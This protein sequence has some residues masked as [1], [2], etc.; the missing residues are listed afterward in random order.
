MQIKE[1]KIY[2]RNFSKQVEFYAKIIGLTLIDIS[3]NQAVFQIGKSKL[4]IVGSDKFKPYHFAINIPC[5]QEIRALKWLKERVEILKNGIHEIQDFDFWNAK[6]IYFYDR[7]HNIVEF[8]ARKNLQ[9]GTEEE[10]DVNSL[11][12]ISEIGIPVSDIETIFN[13]LNAM[14]NLQKYDGGFERFCAIGDE[15]GLFICINKQLKDWF[16]TGDKAHSSA[17]AIKFKENERDYD[18]EF[19][20][21]EIK[22]IANDEYDKGKS[23]RII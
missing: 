6:A 2:A 23:T 10:F 14:A 17:F 19:S 8:I 12:E 7:D 18:L 9:N 11:L 15:N 1:L 4:K 3:E 5:N 13:R 21:G 16:P 22:A 20:N